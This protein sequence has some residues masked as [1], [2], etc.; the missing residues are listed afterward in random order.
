MSKNIEIFVALTFTALLYYGI[1]RLCRFIL[2]GGLKFTRPK[3]LFPAQGE[4]IPSLTS[5]ELYQRVAEEL[6]Q[7]SIRHGLWA[8]AYAEADGDQAK[9]RAAY[10][11]YRVAELQK[12]LCPTD[13]SIDNNFSENTT[14]PNQAVRSG[15]SLT[16]VK[17]CAQCGT[18][19]A[20]DARFC[21][22]CGASVQGASNPDASQNV[23]TSALPQVQ[24]QQAGASF[25]DP[26]IGKRMSI[27][28]YLGLCFCAWA[29]G[30]IV[31]NG[32]SILMSDAYTNATVA[33]IIGFWV[34]KAVLKNKRRDWTSIVAFP[35]I[36]FVAGLLGS[37]IGQVLVSQNPDS[38]NLSAIISFVVAFGLS[39]GLFAVLKSS[40]S[41]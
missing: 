39:F 10:T 2:T 37:V 34:G 17:F 32:V 31:A 7:N 13:V 11:R 18:A 36:T 15:D 20:T 30:A 28:A 25:P 6:R 3:S 4:S 22:K 40:H 29:V 8:K 26:A 24:P 41:G 12:N 1:Y 27:A 38:M 9:T 23:R 33:T 16:D 19:I 14:K 5:D 21:V 35:A